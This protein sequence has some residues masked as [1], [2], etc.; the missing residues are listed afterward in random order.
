MKYK[1]EHNTTLL[2][3][4]PQACGVQEK[5]IHLHSNMMTNIAGF[6]IY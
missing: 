2:I 3:P 6:N 5:G 4:R 1:T